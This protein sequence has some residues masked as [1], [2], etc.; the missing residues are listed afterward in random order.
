[1][2]L[3]IFYTAGCEEFKGAVAYKLKEVYGATVFDRGI[4]EVY[5]GAYNIKRLQYDAQGM[6]DYLAR[7]MT[8]EHALWIVDQDIF[9]DNLNFVMGLAMY[10]LACLVSTYRLNSTGMVAKECVHETGHVMGL[11]HCKNKCVMRF[12]N[13]IEDAELKPDV[14]CERCRYLLNRK[15]IEAGTPF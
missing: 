14:L 1:M 5:E 8:S 3:D 2:K 6:L 11:N 13:S 12:S 10:H 9:Y 15:V 4:M 7:S